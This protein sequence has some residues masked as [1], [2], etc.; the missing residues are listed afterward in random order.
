ME[1]RE[2]IATVATAGLSAAL[3]G[4]GAGE[5][6]A[7][8][9]GRLRRRTYGQE[10]S[11]VGLGG[12]VVSKLEQSE[13]NDIVAWSV[14]KGVTY[15]DVAPTYGN[16]QER[17]GP[18]LKPYR[19]NAFLACK[20]AKRDAE[21]AQAELEESLRLLQTDHLDL[22]QLHAL[23]TVKDVATVLG[24][25]GAMET[26]VRARDKGLVRYLGFSAHSVEAAVAAMD[27][28]DFD[29]VLFPFNV[30]C[31]EN[32]NFGPQVL[33]KARDKN[34][35]CLALK[36]LAWTLL[37]EGAARKYPKCWYQPIDD[38][39]LASL[40]LRYTLDLPVVAALPPGDENLYRL[41]V[42]IALEYKPLEDGE[43]RDLLA[44]IKGVKPIFP[45]SA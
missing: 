19:D 3:A 35:S 21:G 20:T 34:V 23:T 11:I 1:R 32:A 30:V 24:P 4:P 28:F 14:D 31:C 8:R 16:A 43:R 13:A 41:A 6:E 38:R 27:R 18:A 39:E 42:E 26:F 29:S 7:N 2:F 17:L 12:V 10:I 45:Q 40:A 33:E 15:F 37:A 36:A 9:A 5:E 25:A 44:R 22:Y